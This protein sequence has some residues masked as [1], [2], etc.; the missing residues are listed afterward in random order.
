MNLPVLK[1]FKAINCRNG[2][3]RV[4]SALSLDQAKRKLPHKGQDYIVQGMSYEQNN[5][6]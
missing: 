4:V 6:K 1:Q 3:Q 2:R 5:E